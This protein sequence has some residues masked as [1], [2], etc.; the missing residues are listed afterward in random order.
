M[1]SDNIVDLW[2][3][4][5]PHKW[6]SNFHVECLYTCEQSFLGSIFKLKI[7]DFKKKIVFYSVNLSKISNASENFAKC[8]ITKKLEKK[9]PF[10]SFKKYLCD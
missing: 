3:I 10:L 1:F 6:K 2:V 7:W 5:K 4:V 9:N 8:F